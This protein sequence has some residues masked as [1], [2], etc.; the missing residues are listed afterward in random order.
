MKDI[1]NDELK[2]YFTA[3]EIGTIKKFVQWLSATNQAEQSQFSEQES[4][5]E[6]KTEVLDWLDRRYKQGHGKRN[7]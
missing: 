2:K 5:D 4:D 7:N 6:I 1:A 3:V